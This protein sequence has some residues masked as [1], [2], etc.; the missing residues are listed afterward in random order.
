M[1]MNAQEAMPWPSKVMCVQTWKSIYLINLPTVCEC[2]CE[3][4]TDCNVLNKALNKS[5]IY[6]SLIPQWIRL[7]AMSGTY[8]M[9]NVNISESDRAQIIT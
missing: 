5:T 8:V 6:H 3:W 2:E 9:Y 1:E 4:V 7:L